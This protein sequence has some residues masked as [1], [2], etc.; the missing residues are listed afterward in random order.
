MT[1]GRDCAVAASAVVGG[2]GYIAGGLVSPL[3][4]LAGIALTSSL[5]CAAFLLSALFLTR[6]K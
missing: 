4:G 3:V 6:R 1:L 5:L 2:V